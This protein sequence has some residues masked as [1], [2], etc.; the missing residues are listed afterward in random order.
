MPLR[1]PQALFHSRDF[2]HPVRGSRIETGGSHQRPPFWTVLSNE[3][4]EPPPGG[5]MRRFV[6][7]VRSRR[8]RFSSSRTS[9]K[10]ICRRRPSRRPRAWFNRPLK[11]TRS[12][13]GGSG[14]CQTT[15]QE[16]N[17]LAN[18]ADNGSLRAT[19]SGPA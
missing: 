9:L 12:S 6:A 8:S 15:A 1:E 14:I 10:V 2:F 3:D 11:L 19:K 4:S 16:A 18:S 17:H 7:N 13:F 5:E